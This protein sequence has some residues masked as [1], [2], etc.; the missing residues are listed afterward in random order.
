MGIRSIAL[1]ELFESIEAVLDQIPVVVDPTIEV[2]ERLRAQGVEM[3]L[4]LGADT[5]E[6]SVV[7][8][9]EMSGDSGLTNGESGDEG[10]H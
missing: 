3:S 4:A 6:P 1:D 10:S 8:D 2:A 7:E 5:N 9:S